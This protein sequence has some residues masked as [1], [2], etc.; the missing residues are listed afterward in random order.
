MTTYNYTAEFKFIKISYLNDGSVEYVTGG[1]VTD[2]ELNDA[3]NADGAGI[4]NYVRQ[5]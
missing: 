3:I 4:N 2:E 5:S 1:D